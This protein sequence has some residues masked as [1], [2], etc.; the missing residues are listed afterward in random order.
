[1]QGIP[2]LVSLIEESQ[3]EQSNLTVTAVNCVWRL[4][5]M[6]GVTPLVHLCRLFT[7]AGLASKLVRA[8]QAVNQEYKS[9]VQQA[10]VSPSQ[11]HFLF[12]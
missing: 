11:A 4:L 12:R 10:D 5:E 7:K 2:T 8:L 6:H 3:A 9:M 1:M